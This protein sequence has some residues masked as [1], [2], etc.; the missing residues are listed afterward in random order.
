MQRL[1]QLREKIDRIDDELANLLE[2]RM[3][4]VLEIADLKETL[5]MAVHDVK[6]EQKIKQNR[7][8]KYRGLLSKKQWEE[9]FETIF[10]ISK[11]LQ[12]ERML[13]NNLILIGFMGTGKTSVGKYLADHLD[14]IYIDLDEAVETME[15]ASIAE[16][17]EKKGEDYFREAET[18]CLQQLQQKLLSN[19]EGADRLRYVI[20]CGGG[21]VL[22]TENVDLLRQMG[23]IVWL[24][25]SPKTVYERLR[26]LSD[27]PLLQ[28]RNSLDAIADLMR[29][30]Q[31]IYEAVGAEMIMDTSQL[32]IEEVT[33]KILEQ[34][35]QSRD[36][37]R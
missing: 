27:R 14:A 1:D 31:P 8:E 16:I 12:Y 23:R 9:W 33:K 6:R 25:G 28:N 22:R 21:T 2:E 17:F 34:L 18:K 37:N 35:S 29:Q 5:R 30:R 7:A 10:R 3:H 4:F 24:T 11:E 26:K 36:L 32:R 15:R 13:R 19:I 20:A